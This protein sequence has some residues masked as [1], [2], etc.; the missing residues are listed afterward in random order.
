MIEELF[1]VKG[2]TAAIVSIVVTIKS[3]NG[4]SFLLWMEFG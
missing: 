3:Q 4:T 2:V 1:R